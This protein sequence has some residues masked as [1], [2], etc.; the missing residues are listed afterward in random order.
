MTYE[1]HLAAAEAAL[2]PLDEIAWNRIDRDAASREGELHRALYDAALIEGY[3]PVYGGRLLALLEDD[4]DATAVLSIELFEGLR[5]Y[6]A[7]KRYLD[8]VG[9]RSAADADTGLANAR[10]RSAR[11]RSA[12]G[13][14]AYATETVVEHLTHFM[15]SELFAAFFFQRVAEQTREPVLADLLRRMSADEQRHAAAASA[16]LEARVRRD[17]SLA[18]RVVAAAEGFRHYGNDIVEVPVAER[19]DL[20]ALAAFNRRV[21][22]IGAAR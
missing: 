11:V 14:P 12:G 15:G 19:N 8:A 7:L 22:H 16:L 18:A 2:W 20:E 5:H 6:T 21:R 17:P 9:F 4:V 1:T 10:V 13:A 3:L